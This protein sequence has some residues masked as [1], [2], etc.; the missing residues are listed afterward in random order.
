MK[1]VNQK[2]IVL[3]VMSALLITLFLSSSAFAA[4]PT[5]VN[6][7]KEGNVDRTTTEV[8]AK[9]ANH[10]KSLKAFPTGVNNQITDSV[11]SSAPTPV[12]KVQPKVVK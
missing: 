10:V 5:A 4:F 2:K 3:P 11:T 9:P 6:S 8:E 12:I 7:V 1:N